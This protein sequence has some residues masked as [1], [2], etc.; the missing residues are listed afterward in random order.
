M[1]DFSSPRGA[2]AGATVSRCSG[3]VERVLCGHGRGEV[4]V[5]FMYTARER[6]RLKDL[7]YES[8]E[9]DYFYSIC[10]IVS[11]AA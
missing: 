3:G 5:F 9:N 7:R 11:V 1:A 8:E 4:W 2:I 10:N 6:V